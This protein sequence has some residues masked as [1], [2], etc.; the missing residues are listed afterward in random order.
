M[1]D[2]DIDVIWPIWILFC[3]E[4]HATNLIKKLY[5]EN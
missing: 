3:E 4:V 2:F 1:H 5:P